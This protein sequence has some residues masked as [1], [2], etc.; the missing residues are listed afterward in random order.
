MPEVRKA[1]G[2]LVAALAACALL[3][4]CCLALFVPQRALGVSGSVYEGTLERCYRHPVTGAIEDSGGEGA[5][6]T[7]QGMVEGC[8]SPTCMLEVTDGGQYFLTIRLGLVDYTKN[9]DFRVQKWGVGKWSKTQFAVTKKSKKDGEAARDYTIRV[10][11]Q[12]CVVRLSMFVKPIGREVVGFLY[13]TKLKLGTPSGMTPK[14][15]TEKS[16]KSARKSLETNDAKKQGEDAADAADD[17]GDVPKAGASVGSAQGLT[18]SVDAENEAPAQGVSDLAPA[19]LLGA[20]ALAV[21]VSAF[22]I[23]RR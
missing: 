5:Y 21:L 19:L 12:K 18:L 9:R 14:I 22:L 2:A 15:V 16:G 6:S 23:L 20:L 7:G 10:P 11:S 13:P 4:A 8:L 17:S 1:R 3:A